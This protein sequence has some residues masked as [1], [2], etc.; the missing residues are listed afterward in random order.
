MVGRHDDSRPHFR[1]ALAL[2]TE[3][4]DRAGAATTH[5]NLARQHERAGR[6]HEALRPD[7]QALAL[8][9]AA[10]DRA[11][12]ARALNNVGCMRTLLG[13]RD[14]RISLG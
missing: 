9:R 5:V 13:L 12:E 2:F 4:G 11:G 6:H 3:A 1:T 8:F 10:G 7:R 14:S